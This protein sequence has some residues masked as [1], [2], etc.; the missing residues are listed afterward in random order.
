MMPSKKNPYSSPGEKL[1]SLYGLLVLS[2]RAYSLPQLAG[3]FRCSKQTVLRMMEQVERTQRLE[4]ESWKEGHHRWY[5][6]VPPN[7]PLNLSLSPRDLE[8]LLLLRALI[9]DMLPVGIRTNIDQTLAGASAGNSLETS[10]PIRSL[11][12]GRIDYTPFEQQLDLLNQG[13][14]ENRF[15]EIEY[16]AHDSKT[17]KKMIVAP[18][19]LVVFNGAFYFRCRLERA[20]SEK[21]EFYDPLL[22]LHRIKQAFLTGRAFKPVANPKSPK[23]E[24]FGLMPGNPVRLKIHFSKRVAPYVTERQWSAD[25]VFHSQ[26]DGSVQLEMTATNQEEAIAWLLSFGKEARLIEPAKIV[27]QV[28]GLLEE[29]IHCNGTPIS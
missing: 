1:L 25:Q 28:K 24:T 12:K 4:V 3:L 6:A 29:M 18:L 27:R 26:A 13:M 15:C 5:R 8:N 17:P 14:R 23:A 21:G 19:E 16:Q 7:R 11:P 10:L 20:F 22:A 9:E 2:N